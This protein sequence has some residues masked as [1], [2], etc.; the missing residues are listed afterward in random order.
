MLLKM[1]SILME[2]D[3]SH[4]N[5]DKGVTSN[6]ANKENLQVDNGTIQYDHSGS[7]LR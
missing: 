6:P 1:V 4:Y 2:N 3:I 5:K 7:L